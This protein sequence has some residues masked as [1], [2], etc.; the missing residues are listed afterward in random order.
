[1]SSLQCEGRLPMLNQTMIGLA[2]EH[3]D[4]GAGAPTD[5]DM[6]RT[7]VERLFGEVL[8]DVEG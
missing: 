7:A 6:N 4:D 3:V 1:M 8:Y 5:H 2:H